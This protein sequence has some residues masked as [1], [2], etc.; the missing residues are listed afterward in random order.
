MG[1]A[2]CCRR[3]AQEAAEEVSGDA[4]SSC[5]VGTSLPSVQPYRPSTSSYSEIV[6]QDIADNDPD[7]ARA[8]HALEELELR[9][10]R[11]RGH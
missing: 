8:Q 10:R 6:L 7:Y 5:L 9:E 2:C 4:P 1:L 11:R 3:R